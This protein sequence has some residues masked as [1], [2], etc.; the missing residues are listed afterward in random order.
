MTAV[1]FDVGDRV[2]VTNSAQQGRR[3]RSRDDEGV[4]LR[5]EMRDSAS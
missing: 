1:Y 5:P 3:H 4:Q 2:A